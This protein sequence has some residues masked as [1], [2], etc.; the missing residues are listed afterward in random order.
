MIRYQVHLSAHPLF[1]TEDDGFCNAVQKIK[2]LIYL[3][4]KVKALFFFQPSYK[5]YPISIHKSIHEN[6]ENTCHDQMRVN[7]R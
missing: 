7:C 6:G 5:I 1:V 2:I 3:S 4:N